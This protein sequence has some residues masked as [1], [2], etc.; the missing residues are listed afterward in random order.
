MEAYRFFTPPK[1]VIIFATVL[2]VFLSLQRR[3]FSQPLTSRT[4][5]LSAWL[6]LLLFPTAPPAE[7][8]KDFPPLWQ[9]KSKAFSVL[10]VGFGVRRMHPCPLAKAGGSKGKPRGIPTLVTKWKGR[11][12]AEVCT[13]EARKIGET[14]CTRERA[15]PS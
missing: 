15:A 13:S 2:I 5:L 1:M 6:G 8:G 14:A 11:S 12:A 10:L 4:R 9:A 7:G 3:V